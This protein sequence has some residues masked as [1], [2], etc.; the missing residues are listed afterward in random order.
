MTLWALGLSYNG[1]HLHGWQRQ[2]NLPTVQGEL[3]RALSRIADHTVTSH[4]AGRTDRGVHA[5]GQVVSFETSAQRAAGD[6]LRGLNGLTDEALRVDWV[7]PAPDA[8]HPRYS[9][10]A[11]SYQYV[12]LDRGA[13]AANDPFVSNL[14]WCTRSLDADAMHRAGQLLLGEH[15]F[16]SFRGAG[17][18]SATPVRRVNALSVQ[19][20]DNRVVM[21][22]E[23]NAFVLHM[24]RNIARALHDIGRGEDLNLAALLRARDR[25]LL[26]ATAPPGGLYLTQVHYPQ[27][28]LPA[29]AAPWFAFG[30]FNPTPQSLD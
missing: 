30:A 6:W 26:G 1:T 16:S 22:I 7:A 11:R 8:F 27:F 18:Q 25:T 20:Q 5:S 17:C 2:H 23:A 19:R 12:Y 13:T 24:V 21:S 9:A 10:T 4:V 29:P 3:E 28:A 14:T 15:D